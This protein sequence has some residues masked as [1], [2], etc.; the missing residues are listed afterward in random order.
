MVSIGERNES[1]RKIAVGQ[2]DVAVVGLGYVG[3]PLACLCAEK[4]LITSCIDID[5]VK[6]ELINQA[7]CPIADK[8]LQ[9]IF[10]QVKLAA[11]TNFEVIRNTDIVVICVPTPVGENHRPDFRPLESACRSVKPYLKKGQTNYFTQSCAHWFSFGLFI[12]IC[13]STLFLPGGVPE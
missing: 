1:K 2:I 5:S 6:V 13:R 4:K 8:G 12:Q 11:S 3:L 9:E 7:I 10:R